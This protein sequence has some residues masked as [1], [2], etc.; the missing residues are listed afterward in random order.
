[1]TIAK[2]ELKVIEGK[3]IAAS[4]KSWFDLLPYV[5]DEAKKILDLNCYTGIFGQELKKRQGVQVSGVAYY[6]EIANIAQTRLD[7]VICGDLETV[8]FPF[9]PAS[10]DILIFNNILERLRDPWKVLAN[11]RK[12]LA[13]GG[14]TIVTLSN[15]Q[16]YKIILGLLKGRWTYSAYS[17]IG[18]E[19]LRYFTRLEIQTLFKEAGY[20]QIKIYPTIATG[21]KRLNRLTL[22]KL[23]DFFTWEFKIVAS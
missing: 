14:C 13:P 9:T 1:M 3:A 7:E 19:R 10:F 8:E 6:P 20:S 21:A 5:P 12:F 11:T 22:G 18:D 23:V 16:Y 15:V 2:N 17:P 4:P